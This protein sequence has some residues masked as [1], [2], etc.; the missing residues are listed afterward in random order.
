MVSY[1]VSWFFLFFN[2]FIFGCAG[3]SL[4]GSPSLVLESGSYSLVTACRLLVA[5]ASLVAECRLLATLASAGTAHG[6]LGHSTGSVAAAQ[7]LSCSAAHDIF[8]DQDSNLCPLRWQEDS[9]PQSHQ[10]SPSLVLSNL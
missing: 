5:V 7:G 2:L 8:P 4:L 10:G 9:L 3:S 6:L 1:H